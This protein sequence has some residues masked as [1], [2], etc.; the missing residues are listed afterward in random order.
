MFQGAAQLNLDSKG[1]LAIPSRLDGVFQADRDTD[2]AGRVGWLDQ[3]QAALHPVA[4]VE[5]SLYSR[6]E[7]DEGGAY[8]RTGISLG[9]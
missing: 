6:H 1:R 4:A 7:P 5:T 2:G 9:L 8:G 3:A